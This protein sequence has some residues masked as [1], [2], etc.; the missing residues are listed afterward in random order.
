MSFTTSIGDCAGAASTAGAASSNSAGSSCFASFISP[1]I[2]SSVTTKIAPPSKGWSPTGTAT[3][4]SPSSAINQIGVPAVSSSPSNI[5]SMP[6]AD[7][8]LPNLTSASFGSSLGVNANLIALGMSL[9]ASKIV[10]SIVCL[11]NFT[12]CN[13]RNASIEKPFTFPVLI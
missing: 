11:F 12:S 3:F 7:L 10:F 5:K 13:S 4:V 9:I 2:P 6:S 1:A 8:I